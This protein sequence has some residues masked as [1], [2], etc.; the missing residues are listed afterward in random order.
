MLRP[1]LLAAALAA[2]AASG[3]GPQVALACHPDRMSPTRVNLDRDP[4]KEEVVAADLHDCAHTHFEAYV[5]IRDRCHGAWR[6]FDLDSEGEVLR[7]F[8]IV[9]ADGR[10]RRPEVFFVTVRRGPVARGIAEV[11][12]L[13]GRPPACA[14]ARALFRYVPTNP[15]VQSFDVQL[16]DVTRKFPGLEVVLTEGREVAQTITRYRY[17]RARDRYVAYG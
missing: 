11:V 16:K 1:L 6:T 5:H 3:S 8:R 10:T 15:G 7:Q 2:L 17:D 4:A 12:R 13:D 9:N 14:R